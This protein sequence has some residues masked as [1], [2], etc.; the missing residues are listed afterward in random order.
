M[1][2]LFILAYSRDGSKLAGIWLSE[3]DKRYIRIWN[4]R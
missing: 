3:N 2:D 1:P 4:L